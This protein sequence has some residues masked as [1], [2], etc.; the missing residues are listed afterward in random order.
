[1][2][3]GVRR[4][5]A[6]ALPNQRVHS[7]ETLEAGATNFTVLVRFEACDEQL[8]LR[9]YLRGAAARSPPPAVAE[10]SILGQNLIRPGRNST[11]SAQKNRPADRQ[12]D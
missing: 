12:F 11:F 7:S 9:Q 8:V 10:G 2:F 3:N 4:I 6:L 1:M 5:L